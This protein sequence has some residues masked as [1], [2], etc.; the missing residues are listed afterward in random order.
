MRQICLVFFFVK[1]YP[2]FQKYTEPK[3]LPQVDL[4]MQNDFIFLNIYEII[5]GLY[6][7]TQYISRTIDLGSKISMRNTLNVWGGGGVA[8]P[9]ISKF[10]SIISYF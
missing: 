6:Y 3:V 7:F 2:L 4:F 8:A 10:I 1:V 9:K 5:L